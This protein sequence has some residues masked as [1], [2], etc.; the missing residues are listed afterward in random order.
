M[1]GLVRVVGLMTWH[2]SPPQ[3]FSPPSTVLLDLPPYAD[4]VVTLLKCVKNISFQVRAAGLSYMSI[5]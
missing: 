4:L 5:S 2:C 3:V 1:H